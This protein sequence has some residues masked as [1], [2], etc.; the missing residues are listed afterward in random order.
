[1]VLSNISR[2]EQLVERVIDA[3]EADIRNLVSAFTQI[4]FNQKNCHLNYL[5]TMMCLQH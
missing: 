3:V 5:G 4:N 2:P 1:M